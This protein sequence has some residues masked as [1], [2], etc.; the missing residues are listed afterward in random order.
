MS[1]KF[2]FA[3][4]FEELQFDAL[5]SLLV[6]RRAQYEHVVFLNVIERKN[7]AMR[8]GT[9]YGKSKEIQLR[10][11]ANIRFIDWAETLF[12]QG[13]ECGVYIVVGSWSNKTAESAIKEE[14][15]LVVIGPQKKGGL[16]NLFGG[17]D[18]L[19]IVERSNTPV[20]V[21]KYLHDGSAPDNPFSNPVIAIQS[22]ETGRAAMD[23]IETLI[24]VIGEVT[25]IHV[26]PESALKSD[27]AMTVQQAR[28]DGKQLLESFCEPFEAKDIPVNLRV[29]VGNPTEEIEKAA[30]EANTHL[31]VLTPSDKR[32]LITRFGHST[33]QILM[34]DSEFSTLLIPTTTTAGDKAT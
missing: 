2:I 8:R 23:Y 24:D 26:V 12:E 18:L 4:R 5:K 21:Y 9:G 13:M 11:K 7:V 34:E 3:T 17:S 14:A 30:K 25:L 16:L 32:F 22:A 29:Y 15:D 20:M 1:R 10:E 27:S 19:K 6:L 28:K 31:V 33:S